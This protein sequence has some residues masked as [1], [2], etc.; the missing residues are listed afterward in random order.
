MEV[1]GCLAM[2]GKGGGKSSGRV[3]NVTLF[4]PPVDT[5]RVWVV[6]GFKREAAGLFH[7][8]VEGLDEVL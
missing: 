6:L 3:C 1:S 2:L 5:S 8:G 4:V 7:S